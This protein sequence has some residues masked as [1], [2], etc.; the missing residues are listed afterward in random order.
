[1]TN[2]SASSCPNMDR[3]D[4]LKTTGAAVAGLAA[5]SRFG[6]PALRAQ[7]EVDR[8]ARSADPIRLSSNES[9][10]GISQTAIMAILQGT[11]QV[12][13][14]PHKDVADLVG[15]IAAKEQVEVAQV[16]MGFGSADV[17]EGLATWL[18]AKGGE[19]VT[20]DLTFYFFPEAMRRAGATITPVPLGADHGIDLDAMAA[21]VTPAT[22]CVYLVNPNNPTGTLLDAAKLRAFAIKVSATC[23][24]VIDEAYLDYVDD[25][26]ANTM[27]D[28][29]RAGH[30]VIVTRTFSKIHGLAGERIGYGVMPAE[31]AKEAFA[32]RM[33]NGGFRLNYLGTVAAAASL[34]D[35]DFQADVRRQVKAERDKFCAGLDELGR[36]YARP[37]ASFIYFDVGM[38]AAKFKDLMAAENV[39]INGGY[40]L[41]PTWSRITIGTPDEMIV[42]MAAVRKILA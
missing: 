32:G 39:I 38:P 36:A 18:G 11:E 12:I 30:N 41:R 26:E 9:N 35:P 27:V 5:L 13:R 4:W 21:K 2:R 28:L 10:Y 16:A 19:V 29:V 25:F 20:P 15:A 31:L 37:A 7:H 22:R 14:Y 1:M 33:L 17:L 40:P 23:P 34:A 8:S 6:A 24:V 3:R 42:A